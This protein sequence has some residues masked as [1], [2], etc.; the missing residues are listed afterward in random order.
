MTEAEKEA[1]KTANPSLAAVIEAD[2]V[3]AYYCTADGLYG[4][5]YYEAG[6]NYRGLE[7]WSSMSKA[8]R[9]KFEFNYDA[10]DVLI[11][12]RYSKNAEGTSIIHP[13][14]QKYQ[15]D[16]AAGTKNEAEA[17]PAGYSLEKPVDYTATYN[18]TST[19]NYGSGTVAPG[20]EISREDFESIPNEKR[21]YTTIDV[22]EAGNIYVVKSSFQ[23][24]GRQ[25]AI[26]CGL[27][28][29]GK[30]I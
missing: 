18:G 21:H 20:A 12:S 16:S 23:V 1:Y 4:G 10:F 2:V 13:E 30:Y 29:L 8:D 9:E 28:H 24:P 19:L 25:H 7:V 14:G 22:K 17:N 5:N 3:P 15:Y 27:Y 11:D 6:K 26:R